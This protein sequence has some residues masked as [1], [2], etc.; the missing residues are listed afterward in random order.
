LERTRRLWCASRQRDSR[1]FFIARECGD[2]GGATYPVI[3]KDDF[4]RNKRASGRP[5]DLA[6]VADVEAQ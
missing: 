6:D 1:R 3:G 5:K 2:F 4:V